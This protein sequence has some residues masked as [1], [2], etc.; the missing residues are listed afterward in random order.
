[1]LMCDHRMLSHNKAS[2]SVN[3][4]LLSTTGWSSSAASSRKGSHDLKYSER[5][6]SLDHNR[7]QTLHHPEQEAVPLASSDSAVGMVASTAED[8]WGFFVDIAGANEEIPA[9]RTFLNGFT[10]HRNSKLQTIPDSGF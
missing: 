6:V 2:S 7:K 4:S 3:R 1:M 10:L 9:E 5:R 8:D